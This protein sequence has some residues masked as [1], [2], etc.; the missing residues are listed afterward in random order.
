MHSTVFYLQ[1]TF[2]TFSSDDVRTFRQNMVMKDSGHGST[3]M[4]QTNQNKPNEL[5]M[6]SGDVALWRVYTN[7]SV[8]IC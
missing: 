8:P 5:I 1:T 6:V 4:W 3:I 7:N 2:D